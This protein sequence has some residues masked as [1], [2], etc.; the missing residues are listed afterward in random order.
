MRGCDS[1]DRAAG[2]GWRRIWRAG[3]QRRGV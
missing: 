2:A 1:G 3:R